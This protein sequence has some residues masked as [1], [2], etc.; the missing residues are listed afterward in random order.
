MRHRYEKLDE[1]FKMQY[2]PANDFDGSVT[3]HIVINVWAWFDENPEERKRLGW[4]KHL[5]YESNDELLADLP[6]WDPASQYLVAGT[7][8]V[9]EWTVKDVYYT[10]DKTEEMMLLEEM[11]ETMNLYV[12]TGLVQLDAQGGVLV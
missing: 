5:Y 10:I 9:D 11:L 4:I 2:C 7:E 3:G 1:N 12:P 6:D 8:K